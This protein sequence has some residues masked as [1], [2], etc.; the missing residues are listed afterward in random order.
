MFKT[1]EPI[2]WY[3]SEA[4]FDVL[5]SAQESVQQ[6]AK[7]QKESDDFMLPPLYTRH[8]DVGVVQVKGALWHGSTG[9]FRLFGV[10]GYDDIEAA[11]IEGLQDKKA[12]RLMLDMD[13]PG[14]SVK[15][16]KSLGET[17]Q[18]IGKIK[19]TTAFATAANSAAYWLAS[20][21]SHI[22]LDEMGEAGSIGC[23]AVHTEYSK[24]YEKEGVTKTAIRAGE[25]KA[26][27]SPFEPLSDK[28]REQIQYGVNKARDQFVNAVAQN[29]GVTAATVESQYGQGKVFMG[30][31]ALRAGLVD[32]V[33]GFQ[34]A[35]A[36]QR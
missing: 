16:L 4:A 19:S 24:M 18:G 23:I 30:S 7:T 8:G 34:E 32:A 1:K 33:G 10:L 22:T 21:T 28:A 27:A 11:L 26:L 6:W 15:G 9:I 3:G 20:A 5:A 25:N 36:Y 14:G 31:D 13:S 29:R 35:L 2:L 17:I 12:K